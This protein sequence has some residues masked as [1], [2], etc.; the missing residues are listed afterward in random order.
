MTDIKKN[1]SWQGKSI[2]RQWMID[3]IYEVI[4]DKTL[5]TWCQVSIPFNKTIVSKID[6]QWE[7]TNCR[8]KLW[9]EYK[10]WVITHYSIAQHHDYESSYLEINDEDITISFITETWWFNIMTQENII[11]LSRYY[12]WKWKHSNTKQIKFCEWYYWEDR[13][14][15][16]YN[17]PDA[18]LF[19][20][21]LED[22]VIWHPVMIWNCDILIDKWPNYFDDWL[23]IIDLWIEKRKPIEEQSDHCV[24]YIYS[25][26]MSEK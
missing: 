25:L 7:Y 22:K 13:I 4:S 5:N 16:I 3:K 17:I 21:E 8:K 24:K 1:T 20:D 2:D 23:P 6:N 14:E 26:I 11:R 19:L 10:T 15:Y 9:I 12:E 18:G